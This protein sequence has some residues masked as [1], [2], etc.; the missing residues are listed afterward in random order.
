MVTTLPRPS[1]TFIP[2]QQ[3]TEDAKELFELLESD[4]MNSGKTL[5]TSPRTRQTYELPSQLFD[6]LLFVGEN[7]AQGRGVSV[8]PR[9]KQLTTQEAA[10]FLGI[11]RPTLVKLLETG[12]IPFTKVGRHR[13]IIL[14][15]LFTYQ[16]QEQA[17]RRAVL[18]QA[19]RKGQE[20]GM[21]ELTAMSEE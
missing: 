11:S 2:N 10:D 17:R 3:E 6:V 4:L 7:L 14:D 1:K 9:A 18:A 20:A 8:I 5:L 16:E 15:D 13:R 12:A 21:L 19:A